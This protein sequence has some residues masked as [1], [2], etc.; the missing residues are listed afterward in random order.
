[1]TKSGHRCPVCE[2][3]I[4]AEGVIPLGKEGESRLDDARDVVADALQV[5]DS[6]LLVGQKSKRPPLPS[7][8]EHLPMPQSRA[9]VHFSPK[10]TSSITLDSTRSMI[11]YDGSAIL[12]RA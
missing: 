5:L 10:S 2:S 12:M 1:M 9:G 8:Y 4:G 7:G 11:L 6:P 3:V